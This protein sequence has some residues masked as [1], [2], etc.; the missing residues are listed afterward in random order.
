MKR[1]VFIILCMYAWNPGNA[2]IKER[3][4]EDGIFI[5]KSLKELTLPQDDAKTEIA[6]K[7]AEVVQPAIE[8]IG[9]LMEADADTYKAYQED[10]K[11]VDGAKTMEEKKSRIESISKKYYPFI[12]K[13]WEQAN[14]DERYYQAKIKEVFPDNVKDRIRFSEFLRFEYELSV[15]V[16]PYTPGGSGLQTS[17]PS[18]PVTKPDDPNPFLCVDE[19]PKSRPVFDVGKSGIGNN[20]HNYGPFSYTDR[21]WSINT[22][23]DSKGPWGRWSDEGITVDTMSIPGRFPLDSRRLQIVKSYK[24]SGNAYAVS[25][26]GTSL[27]FYYETPFNAPTLGDWQTEVGI[28]SPI[29]FVLYSERNTTKT[30]S[31]IK[32]KPSGSFLTFGFGAA[33]FS[34]ASGLAFAG[35]QSKVAGGKWTICEVP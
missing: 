2:Q 21:T 6:K 13:I 27:G 15:P 31:V 19:L 8:K 4:G 32:P 22:S 23:T 33:N 16:Q 9:K 20:S 35:A 3:A 26:L 10:I 11:A 25:V 28:C 30:Y 12:K 34:S 1:I 14:I 29:T 5:R 24:W 7:I 17:N 18:T